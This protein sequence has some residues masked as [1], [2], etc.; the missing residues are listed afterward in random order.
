MHVTI[1][2]PYDPTPPPPDEARL[3]F[4]GGVERVLLR[5]AREVAARGHQVT[6]LC[7][8]SG[9][10]RESDE[11]GVRVVRVRRRATLLRAPVAELAKHLPRDADLVQVPGT[12][13]FTTPGVLRAAARRDLPCI[14]D[15]H[16]EPDPGT[17][18]GRAAARAYRLIGPPSY[19]QA[20]LVMVR[21]LGYGLSAPSLRN[22]PLSRWRVVPNG[23]D[24]AAFTPEGP[25]EPSDILV[26]GRLVPYKGVGVL[27][28]AASMVPDLPRVTV[29]GDGPL[30]PRLEALA[31][32]LGVRA[33]F[34]GRAPE[35]GLAALY[36][37][38]KLTVLPS[39]NRQE[40][41]GCALV[42]SMACGTPVVA[43]RLPGVEE[44]AAQ[45]GLLAEPGDARSLAKALRLGLE[46]GR[47]ARGA[48]L[49]EKVA[50]RYA[51]SRVADELLEVYAE[52]LGDRPAR[53]PHAE[54]VAAARARGHPLL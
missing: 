27:L 4:V 38:A 37:G 14:L 26:V 33:R 46:P 34:L 44:V 50:A 35:D 43:S 51:W 16:F 7:T 30:R 41:F 53:A 52:A 18:H 23:V 49:A 31:R 3:A 48:V 9:A 24:A 28:H 45:G 36:R 19:R 54:V 15:F 5:Q 47:L 22:V 29:V 13:P 1:V 20:R 8:T 39:I 17:A 12:Y 2:S 6:L 42:E 21:S 25:A 10:P 32:K 40:A 11:H